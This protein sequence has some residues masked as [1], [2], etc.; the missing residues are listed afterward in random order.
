MGTGPSHHEVLG[1][2]GAT[3]TVHTV[4]T[5]EAPAEHHWSECSSS[6]SEDE[7]AEET[8][9]EDDS[10][11]LRQRQQR[12]A[13]RRAQRRRVRVGAAHCGAEQGTKK[14]DDDDA[15]C[16]G[17][18]ASAR[19]AGRK[20]QR[21]QSSPGPNA[22][23]S[24][25]GVAPLS[26][27]QQQGS[28][29]EARTPVHH[30]GCSGGGGES[31][32]QK[33]GEEC[34]GEKQRRREA[35]AAEQPD[36]STRVR[37]F[38]MPD[39]L[40]LD[41]L[42]TYAGRAADGDDGETAACSS[43]DAAAAAAAVASTEQ[44]S[45]SNDEPP[46]AGGYDP[47]EEKSEVQG[48]V[49]A[50]ERL[51]RR[52][53]RR[54]RRRPRSPGHSCSDES[55]Q[56][57]PSDQ[58]PCSPEHNDQHN[59]DDI[60]Q[61]AG[62]HLP[63]ADMRPHAVGGVR[64]PLSTDRSRRLS[65]RSRSLSYSPSASA[66]PRSDGSSTS[67]GSPWRRQS[68][69]VVGAMYP[70]SR[71]RLTPLPPSSARIVGALYPA[72]R[73]G[74]YNSVPLFSAANPKVEAVIAHICHHVGFWIRQS[75][76]AEAAGSPTANGPASVAFN[77]DNFTDGEPAIKPNPESIARSLNWL[78][79]ALQ[80]EPQCCVSLAVYL[81]R[82]RARGVVVSRQN[83]EPLLVSAVLVSTKFW[84]DL[85]TLNCDFAQ[86]L[87]HYS[88]S[89]LN[90]ME[91]QFIRTLQ[92]TLHIP[93]QEYTHFYFHLAGP[94][95]SVTDEA[96]SNCDCLLQTLSRPGAGHVAHFSVLEIFGGD[97]GGANAPNPGVQSAAVGV[98]SDG[99]A[100][101][102]EMADLNDDDNAD[103]GD[104][105]KNAIKMADLD[106][107][108]GDDGKNASEMA[109]PD[110][111]GGDDGKNAS[112]MA[113]LDDDDNADF[114]GD[115]GKH[116]RELADLDDDDN[117][118]SGG[119][120][121]ENA[122]EMVDLDDDD[123]IVGDDGEDFDLDDSHQHASIDIMSPRSALGSSGAAASHDSDSGS[124]IASGRNYLQVQ[125]Q[126]LAML[127][128]LLTRAVGSR[129]TSPT[130][131]NGVSGGTESQATSQRFKNS[132]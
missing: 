54:T 90:R 43:T 31:L 121:G 110:D 27:G 82:A 127:V 75:D 52:H 46:R 130:N 113:G 118:N 32:D 128:P 35:K 105:G 94:T 63:L 41:D 18:S 69:D 8:K 55:E 22:A 26:G 45:L 70:P 131:A 44:A 109:G 83:Y 103:G 116:A 132:S 38:S 4:C 76:A 112:E 30:D 42:D 50:E 80:I 119:E 64:S 48:G 91:A 100:N 7:G 124:S 88:L 85:S 95:L 84:D 29:P 2:G 68:S 20:L 104:D 66:S 96:L 107:D 59:T 123:D 73:S 98:D 78:F 28:E 125:Q 71:D 67:G 89:G 16:E 61:P 115:N 108:G 129:E 65:A 97:H 86:A 11:S 19:R 101:A 36:T 40:D 49:P 33:V 62:L 122:K 15:V 9:T 72:S 17:K 56:P 37:A 39:D 58:A 23:L 87:P 47:E 81:Q 114:G 126:Q 13:Q 6:M 117:A 60:A 77:V 120:G 51:V 10:N 24:A 34:F 111:D 5:F 1:G 14:R 53:R 102:S 92:W 93:R 21:S 12:R 57:L 3:V 79:R 25:D 106:D 99:E 74:V